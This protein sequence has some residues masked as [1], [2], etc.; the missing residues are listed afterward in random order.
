MENVWSWLLPESPP[1]ATGAA[2][3]F[4]DVLTTLNEQHLDTCRRLRAAH[5]AVRS[6]TAESDR[7]ESEI[8]NEHRKTL[9]MLDREI[10]RLTAERARVGSARD[11]YPSEDVKAASDA[12]KSSLADAKSRLKAVSDQFDAERQKMTDL[13]TRYAQR[14]Q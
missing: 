5:D 9:A 10:E 6:S 14:E 8:Q 11:Y 13:Y 12:A 1:P 4:E 2:R 7:V 3:S